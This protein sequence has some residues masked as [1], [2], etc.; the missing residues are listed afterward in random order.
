[1]DGSEL[2]Y[3]YVSLFIGLENIASMQSALLNH[4]EAEDGGKPSKDFGGRY[5]NVVRIRTCLEVRRSEKNL[6]GA[7]LD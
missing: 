1:V 3:T 4:I 5:R 6:I 2:A 7:T